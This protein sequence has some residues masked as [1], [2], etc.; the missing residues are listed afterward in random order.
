M[1]TPTLQPSAWFLD[2]LYDDGRGYMEVVAGQTN[3]HNPEKINLVM[4]TRRWCYYDPERPDLRDEAADYI[5]ELAQQ[6]GNV[7]VSSR[8]YTQEAK[9]QNQR[10]EDRTLPSRVIFIDDAPDEPYLRYSLSVRTST[11]PEE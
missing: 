1:S 2:W 6:Y 9:A 11:F 5:A 3:P 10:S 8:L 4:Q 7:Y